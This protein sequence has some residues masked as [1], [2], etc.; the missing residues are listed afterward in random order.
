MLRGVREKKME[1][2]KYRKKKRDTA[3]RLE[4][5]GRWKANRAIRALIKN[6]SIL[7][8]P[9]EQRLTARSRFKGSR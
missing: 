6:V 1:R 4:P 8:L 5:A 9:R 3:R 7:Q 2:R